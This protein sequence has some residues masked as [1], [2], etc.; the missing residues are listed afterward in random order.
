MPEPR[1]E[2]SLP[3]FGLIERSK[4]L[5]Y[6]CSAASSDLLKTYFLSNLSS[7][8]DS[9]A[10]REQNAEC[11]LCARLHVGLSEPAADW[12]EWEQIKMLSPCSG[13]PVSECVTVLTS[14][15]WQGLFT[16]GL[17]V[18]PR[19]TTKLSVCVGWQVFAGATED[20]QLCG[21]KK[22]TDRLGFF[23]LCF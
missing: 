3:H 5:L 22:S 9:S 23:V 1:V 16:K 13:S 20:Q 15:C 12:P 18:I 21:L 17:A 10:G 19:L 4:I 2:T 8:V 7:C 14:V 11:P 6:F